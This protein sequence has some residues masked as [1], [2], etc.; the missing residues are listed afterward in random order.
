MQ[1]KLVANA[2]KCKTMKVN[3]SRK[4]DFP[5]EA[6]LGTEMLQQVDQMK[7][8]GITITS[9]LKWQENTDQIVRRAMSRIWILRRMK[10]LGVGERILADVWAKEG[11]SLLELA[12]PAWHSS[13]T[14]K[15]SAAIE[16]CQRV[17]VATISGAGWR[18]YDATLRRL[19]LTRLDVRREKLCR[20]FAT[21]TVA[22]SRHQDLFPRREGHSHN[23]RQS[24][25]TFQEVTCRTRRRYRSARPYLTRLLNKQ[26]V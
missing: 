13:L 17:A 24:A 1:N 10:Q 3:F 11:R 22:R 8:L 9:D 15:Q 19:G 21:R 26:L 20:T 2:R 16:R 6:K 7:I 5:L 18:E 12:V 14:L 25:T 4:Y 23:T